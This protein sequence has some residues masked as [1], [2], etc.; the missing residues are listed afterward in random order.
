MGAPRGAP[1]G[2]SPARVRRDRPVFD[3]FRST[4]F[5]LPAPEFLTVHDDF[6]VEPIP[7]LPDVPPDGERILWQ[8]TPSWRVL[9][10]RLF[11]FPLI[12]LYFAALA[13]WS[14]ASAAHDGAPVS[15]VAVTVIGTLAVGVALLAVLALVAWWI[16]RS[17]VYTITSERVAIR[18]GLALPMTVNF[19]FKVIGDANQKVFHNGTGNVSFSLMRGHGVAWL[20]M[21]PHVRPWHWARTQ[22]ML[23]GLYDA[24]ATAE[25]LARALGAHAARMQA[26][27]GDGDAGDQ[28]RVSAGGATSQSDGS[29]KDDEGSES[30]TGGSSVAKAAG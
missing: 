16:E 26:A 12:A 1:W 24:R 28:V 18:Y 11:Q 22:P 14:G 5:W 10:R 17:T 15:D 29:V 6:A 13:A 2:G 19:P 4:I 27:S 9:A 30:G 3:G 20:L 8:G 7:G 21:W 23:R 25:V